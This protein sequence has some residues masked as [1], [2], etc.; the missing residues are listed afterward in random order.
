MVVV[1]KYRVVGV[2]EQQLWLIGYGLVVIF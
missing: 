2:L 1:F